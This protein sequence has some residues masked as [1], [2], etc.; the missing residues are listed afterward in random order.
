MPASPTISTP[1]STRPRN[2]SDD[3]AGSTPTCAAARLTVSSTVVVGCSSSCTLSPCTV[4]T[5]TR[6]S[7]STAG[8]GS[9]ALL[10][11]FVAQLVSLLLVED[12]LTANPG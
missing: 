11:S 4:F 3:A 1:C 2:T 9:T 7:L 6:I 12:E 10:A 5:A 8:R